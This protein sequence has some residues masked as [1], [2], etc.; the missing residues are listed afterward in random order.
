[1]LQRSF[2]R[3]DLA[4]VLTRWENPSHRRQTHFE[5][6]AGEAEIGVRLAGWA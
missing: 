3:A 1:V 6:W 2:D 5:F 4:A